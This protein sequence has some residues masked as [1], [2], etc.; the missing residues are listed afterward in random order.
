MNCEGLNKDHA[1][2]DIN[3]PF[4]MPQ[5]VLQVLGSATVCNRV[6]DSNITQIPFLFVKTDAYNEIIILESYF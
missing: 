6:F 5:V 4:A 2:A 1:S 3:R